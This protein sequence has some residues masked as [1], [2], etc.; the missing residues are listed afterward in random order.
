MQHALQ[1]TV[2]VFVRIQLRGVGRKEEYFQ[3]AFDRLALQPA[4]YDF[5]VVYPQVIQDQ[6]D[7]AGRRFDQRTQKFL[8]DLGGHGRLIEH[9][10]YSA[11]VGDRRDHVERY[12]LGRHRLHWCLS[13]WCIAPTVLG[14][15]FDTR[16]VTPE[17][18]GILCFGT[19]LNLRVF[20]LQP[21]VNAGR[22]LLP[23]FLQWLLRREAPALEV[24]A[25][26]AHRDIDAPELLDQL[27]NRAPCP[28]RKAKLVL[29]GHL[30]TNRLDDTLFL[31]FGQPSRL[32][33]RATF[34]NSDS[35][36][37]TGLIALVP[38]PDGV[39]VN[40]KKL[41]YLAEGFALLAESNRLL[42]EKFL[43]LRTELACVCIHANII[44]YVNCHR[45][46]NPTGVCWSLA[47]RQAVAKL[48]IEYGVTL[49]EDAPYRPLRFSGES[50][51]MVSSFCPDQALVLRSF[52]K[53]ASP[54]LRIGVVSGPAQWIE[55]LIKV[56]QGADLHSNVPAQAMLLGLLEHPEFE[57][58]IAKVCDLYHGRYQVLLKA[59]EQLEPFGCQ[60]QPVAGGMFV[61]LTLPDCDSF[62][63]AK[64]LIEQ[65]VATVPSDVFYSAEKGV[66]AL[67]LNFTNATPDM[68][69]EAVSRM[70]QAL[71]TR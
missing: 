27:S 67:R 11:L 5:G 15:V 4:L 60:A 34:L 43:L 49:L 8:Q 25:H 55:P 2:E 64:Y 33:F 47:T 50:L 30:V 57:Q 16:L 13:L 37:T 20:L 22:V 62:A 7:L 63:L 24:I 59:L 40:V 1:V 35:V 39:R 38:A 68:L 29:V 19:G 10:S 14:I 45:V 41:T 31:L 58:H 51:P 70:A 21:S 71:A 32:V 44:S 56:K 3:I 18:L 46:N 66:S 65:G 9:E 36:S 26:R 54:G 28:K 69:Q 17:N 61:W 48:C 6:K 53:I 23:R 42:P 12:T 52:S